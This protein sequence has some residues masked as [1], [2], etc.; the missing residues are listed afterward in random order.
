MTYLN[1]FIIATDPDGDN[2]SY[3]VSSSDEAVTVSL[4]ENQLTL[5]PDLD[6]NGTVEIT[7]TVE[8]DGDP[9]LSDTELFDLVVN[10]VNDAP[11]LSLIGAQTVDEDDDLVITLIA[12]DVE[13]D[14]INYSC[15]IDNDNI[16][17]NSVSPGF[18]LT[19][20]TKATNTKEE[21]LL[22][23]SKIP[24]RRMAQPE[25]IGNLSQ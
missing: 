1:I 3:S 8:D 4:D 21:I 24:M 23:E 5:S 16:L 6:W 9:S 18:T 17:V 12:D 13:G 2:L 25:E 10:A 7:V 11:I 14:N 19:E 22:H 20:L 15:S